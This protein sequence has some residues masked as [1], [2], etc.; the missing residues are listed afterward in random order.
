MPICL[1]DNQYK[2]APWDET[3]R[4]W[5]KDKFQDPLNAIDGKSLKELSSDKWKEKNGELLVF[6]FNNAETDL[7]RDDNFV[8][9]LDWVK[10]Q[11]TDL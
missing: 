5:D 4:P 1:K 6:S 7:G 11:E 2:F 9:K 3:W 10:E 8:Y